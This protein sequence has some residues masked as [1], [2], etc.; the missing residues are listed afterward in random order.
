MNVFITY[1]R[2]I[3]VFLALVWLSGMSYAEEIFYDFSDEAQAK[4]DAEATIKKDVIRSQEPKLK[5]SKRSNKQQT[6]TAPQEIILDTNIY[7]RNKANTMQGILI[8]SGETFFA[9]LQSSISSASI[10]QDDAIAAILEYDWVY[11][12]TLIAPKGSIVYGY[13]SDVKKAGIMLNDG[14][15]SITFNEIIT[16][17]GYKHTL[18]SNTVTLD[19]HS[20][21]IRRLAGN[22]AAGAAAGILS[23]LLYT[24]ISGGDI[25]SGIAIGAGIGAAGGVVTTVF[26]NGED[27]EI[28]AGT[29]IKVELLED[30]NVKSYY[31]T[32]Q[33]VREF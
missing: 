14:S 2:Y 3:T 5:P 29:P 9:I 1:K 17:D 23:G 12:G 6:K 19:V 33:T 13:A 7:P 24:L 21:K 20:K 10:A 28:P 11:N 26:Q 31:G 25:V 27:V 8:K 16:P 22:T 4:F 32:C 18:T 30:M 15:L